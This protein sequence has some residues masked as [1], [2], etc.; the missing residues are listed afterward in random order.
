MD[1][2]EILT[3]VFELKDKIVNSFL[4]TN[5][6]EKEKRMLDDEECF[7]LLSLYQEKQTEYNE[8]K[9]FE[10]YGSDVNKASKELSEIKIKVDSNKFV[11]EYNEAYKLM[12]KELKKIEK[13][14]FKDIF[15]E[16]KEIEI[17]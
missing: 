15:K 10:K 17:E 13:I 1:N 3:K 6:K 14:I 16:R 11:K 12:C 2:S 7:K 5:L 9:R 8:A 4:Y